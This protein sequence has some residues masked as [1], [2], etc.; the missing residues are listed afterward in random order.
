MFHSFQI[1]SKNQQLNLKIMKTH[2]LTLA[3]FGFLFQNPMF[4]QDRTT[5]NATSNE[6]SDNLDLRAVASIF[7]DSKDLQDFEQ[8]L[9]DPRNKISNLDLNF[10]RQV[11]YLRVIEAV[12]KNTHLIILQAV[13]EKDVFQDVATIEVERDRNNQL[14]IQVVGDVFMYGPNYIYEPVYVTR[15]VIY[16]V[17]WVHNYNPYYSPYYFNYYPSYYYAWTPYPVYRYRRNVH[18]HINEYNY[19][20]YSNHRK[21]S[22][23]VALYETR[24]TN[25]YERNYDSYA[26]RRNDHAS[27][28]N[29]SNTR[30]ENMSTRNVTENTAVRNTDENRKSTAT[31]T[32]N[33]STR[34]LNSNT[35][36]IN[37]DENRKTAGTRNDNVSTRNLSANT[38]V[39]NTDENRKTTETRNEFTNSNVRNTTVNTPTRTSN[40]TATRSDFAQQN[41]T[42][43]LT[44]PVN[45]TRNNSILTPTRNAPITETKNNV[46]QQQ[47]YREVRQ[48]SNSNRNTAQLNAAP[49][50]NNRGN[51]SA[52]RTSSNR[53]N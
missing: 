51:S 6:I 31:R 42:Q 10:D 5:V 8:R 16:N 45:S 39:R 15:P 50:S 33:T 53:R 25:G 46:S 1:Q 9:N 23:A 12:E 18:I 27:T 44:N 40:N 14:Q 28:R 37:T 41:S 34:N 13:L 26:T 20:N 38:A 2:L 7:G 47:P 52:N 4:A 11:D 43:S 36:V 22:N 30:G 32:D 48:S 35:A 24:R 29:T 19:Y 21:S 3:L 17:F 49:T